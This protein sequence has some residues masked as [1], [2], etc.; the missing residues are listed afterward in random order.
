MQIS[1]SIDSG[2]LPAF[3]AKLNRQVPIAADNAVRSS[4]AVLHENAINQMRG[5]GPVPASVIAS[6]LRVSGNEA[7]ASLWLGQLPVNAAFIGDLQQYGSG[8]LAGNQFFDKAFI[9]HRRGYDTLRRRKPEAKW[10][11]SQKGTYPIESVTVPIPG[12]P[13]AEI[14]GNLSADHYVETFL[15]TLSLPE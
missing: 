9:V 1:V 6:R 15:K 11:P 8:S 7:A 10:M 3:L 13:N 2:D 12:Q 4:V 5:K 14:I